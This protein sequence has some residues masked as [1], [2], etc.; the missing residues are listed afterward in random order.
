M[1]D[2]SRLGAYVLPGRVADPRPAVAQAQAAEALGLGAVW[3]GERFG[4]K[5]VAALAGAIGQATERVRIGTAITTLRSRHHVAVAGMAMTLQALSDGRFVLGVGR[6][7]APFW[8]SLG[9]PMMTNRALV[10]GADIVR[11]LCRGEKVVY[12][13]PAGQVRSRL[14]DLPD[15][16]PPPILLAAIG[17]KT[18]ALAGEHFDGVIL[19]PFLTVDGVRRSAAAVRAAAGAAGRDPAAV[20]VVATVVVAAELPP[21]E[22]Q[23]VVAA[24]AVTYFQIPGFGELLADVNGWPAEPLLELRAHPQLAQ[25]RGSADGAF[26]RDQLVDVSS[27]LPAEWL[28][29]ASAT[30]TGPHCAARLEEF[31]DAGATELLLHGSTPP[32]LAPAL[33]A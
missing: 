4:T 20:R 22:E 27:L 5:D 11:R 12:D 29:A 10:D 24:R 15:V 3:I 28:A 26:T 30:G 21:E 13:G 32:Q 9:L 25:L 7:V 19:H 1:P 16:E 23:E 8:R 17:P 31:L 18:L 6:S 14:G 2:H 33:G